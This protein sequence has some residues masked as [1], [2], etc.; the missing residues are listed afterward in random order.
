MQQ[1]IFFAWRTS[2]LGAPFFRKDYGLHFSQ[3]LDG[4]TQRQIATLLLEAI[5]FR[6]THILEEFHH[7]TPL[8]QIYLSGGLSELPILQHGISQCIRIPVAHLRQKETSLQGT[9]ML[10][11]GLTI[12]QKNAD[13]IV[14]PD[15]HTALIK[16]YQ[17]WK[18]WL[19]ALLGIRAH[20]H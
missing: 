15:T 2:G 16:K 7:Q 4:L 3:T 19:D 12:T 6:V 5:I 10:A 13:K 14:S 20:S 1:L 11:S 8:T 18:K 9:A 17:R